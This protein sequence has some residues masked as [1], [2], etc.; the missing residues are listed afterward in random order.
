MIH[1]DPSAPEQLSISKT[2]TDYKVTAT[3]YYHNADM[4]LKVPNRQ[5]SILHNARP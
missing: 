3:T 1:I 4:A 5:T 2:A